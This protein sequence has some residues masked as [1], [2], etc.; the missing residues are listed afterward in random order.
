MLSTVFIDTQF[1]TASGKAIQRLSF[2]RIIE[3]RPAARQML[4]DLL[5]LSSIATNGS[6]F[7]IGPDKDLSVAERKAQRDFG[8][9]MSRVTDF[10]RAKMTVDN[11]DAIRFWKSRDFEH[12][13]YENDIHIAE[14][15]DYF[16]DP[17][18]QTGYR[19]LNFKLAVP[20]GKDKSGNTE[21]QVVELQIVAKQI[22]NVYD[23]THIYKRRAEDA[24]TKIFQ[25][26]KENNIHALK[27]KELSGE[28]LSREEDIQLKSFDILIK[29]LKTISRLNYAACRL[30]NGQ[31]S[32]SD[33]P[34]HD[35]QSLIAP[36]FK[37]K[38]YLYPG[39][40]SNLETM[41]AKADLLHHEG[42]GNEI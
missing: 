42:Y 22:E 32:R 1:Q 21:H 41:K 25:L 29:P 20:V 7:I 36:E 31:A 37:S 16:E 26:M 11:T 39:R 3:T 2:E 6:Q 18:D 12:I 17:K 14:I 19:C 27:A 10:V 38:H 8:S 33:D 15:N 40:E 30:I 4:Q 5:I 35:F 34:K 24:E 23:Q 9:D 13:L 28:R